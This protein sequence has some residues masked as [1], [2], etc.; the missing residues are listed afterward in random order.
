VRSDLEWALRQ[1]G[2]A[3][4]LVSARRI[5]FNGHVSIHSLV[6]N[7]RG[8]RRKLILRR[9]V[10]RVWLARE[11][12][13]A[14]REAKALRLLESAPGLRTPRLVAVDPQGRETSA[15]AVL[16]S[17]LG[18]KEEWKPPSIE[19]FAAV[20]PVVHQVSAPRRFRR[21]RRYYAGDGL[22]P[23]AWSNQPKL[24]ERAFEVAEAA[25][26][27]EATACFIH[28]DHHA[29]NVLWSYGRVV[30]V[31]D[32]EPACIGPPAI[33]FAHVRANLAAWMGIGAARRYAKC[34]DVEVDPVWDI[35]DAV[36]FGEDQL[37]GP[38]GRG[39]REAFVADAL[40]EL[41]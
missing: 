22:R 15:P 5:H 14:A 26:V 28:R 41:G 33:D 2:P 10:D 34:P 39:G 38:N 32:W 9:Y 13:L 8:V 6:A 19:R 1:L 35:V 29:G 37:P 16:M 20:A 3:A 12:D 30:G 27:D 7:H 24:W 11:P 36:D 25:Q 40:S 31:I 18:G 17:H 4:E 23:P 21:Y